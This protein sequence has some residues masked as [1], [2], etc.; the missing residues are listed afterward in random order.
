MRRNNMTSCAWLWF[1]FA[2][3]AGLPAAFGADDFATTYKRWKQLESQGDYAAALK[4]AEAV[5]AISIKQYG[6][7]HA[8]TGR[9]LTELA[10]LY[11]ECG[12]YREA[13]ETGQRALAINEKQYGKESAAAATATLHLG[14]ANTW[15]RR[16]P[17]A[18]SELER[19]L[20]YLEK[21][22]PDHPS[23]PRVAR[24]LCFLASEASYAKEAG[25]LGKRAMELAEKR[26]G[27]D[28]VET[29]ITRVR[30]GYAQYV[31]GE[32]Q[33][34]EKSLQAALAVL[35]SKL[36]KEHPETAFATYR[37]STVYGAS[38]REK[39]R[40]ECLA[41]AE[42]TFAAKLGPQ[43]MLLGFVQND[44]GV[45]AV[46]QGDLAEAERCYMRSLEL[47]K[48]CEAE[49]A[50][51]LINLGIVYGQRSQ[52]DKAKTTF[53]RALEMSKRLLGP[54]HERV[55]Y[56]MLNYGACL[57]QLGN[58]DECLKNMEGALAIFEKHKG[59]VH[60]ETMLVRGNLA[61]I[62]GAVGKE[63]E[64]DDLYKET[65]AEARK[66]LGNQ[67]PDMAHLLRSHGTSLLMR[68]QHAP[69][70]EA[71]RESH[72]IL[73][74]NAGSSHP[75]GPLSLILEAECH[76]RSGDWKQAM[77]T[78][79]RGFRMQGQLA[80]NVLPGISESEQLDFLATHGT[81][82][83]FNALSLAVAQPENQAVVDRT[84]EWTLNAKAMRWTVL[85]ERARRLRLT[86][87]P[88]LDRAKRELLD[89]RERLAALAI[90]GPE[91]GAFKEFADEVVDLTRR[92]DEGAV[93]LASAGAATGEIR[94]WRTLDEVRAA[95]PKDAVLIE[96]A[97]HYGCDFTQPSTATRNPIYGAWIIPPAGGGNVRFTYLGLASEIEQSIA[98]ARQTIAD[99]SAN[100]GTLG[101]KQS[102]EQSREA[103]DALAKHILRPL[104]SAVTKS[105]RWIVSADGAL[106]LVP[107]AALPLENKSYVVE[108]HTICFVA[109]GRDLLQAPSTST[110]AAKRAV[111][112]ADPDYDLGIPGV[113]GP[114][115]FARLP[116]TAREAQEIAPRLKQLS[117]ED[118]KVFTG[119]QATEQLVKQIAQTSTL[120]LSTHGFF[121][122][123]RRDSKVNPLLCCG[124]ALA[125]ANQRHHATD[126][127]DGILTGLEVI[128]MNLSGTRLVVLS[129]CDT[130]VGKVLHGEGVAGLRQA[131]QL[132][133]A[134]S[135]L[136]S[137]W[138]VADEETATLMSSFFQ[139]VAAGQDHS[140]ALREAQLAM[141]KS[142]RAAHDA[143]HP[144]FW[145]SFSLTSSS[146]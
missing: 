112:V 113:G 3:I 18:K 142:R 41:A 131:F 68:G 53:E 63:Q 122:D 80:T 72:A 78:G 19:S 31:I 27:A 66:R 55:G 133:G 52:L 91:N 143:A 46:G 10:G 109:T 2:S 121:V 38:G 36:G 85:S 34:A 81:V 59:L 32:Y 123:V 17:Q 115:G 26:F 9:V 127:N 94:A 54:D 61:L 7:A 57:A 119:E 13:S 84:A 106:W 114:L 28:H 20:R 95:I 120:L 6:A 51:T 42:K 24:E 93:K 107:W 134:D 22:S 14:R 4:E 105:P 103:L 44:Y 128:S 98:A 11:V 35:E 29:A 138:S 90:R 37:L 75:Q 76:A 145:A 116:G 45:M 1:L 96:L 137:L 110:A 64:A 136:A 126:G 88:E 73:E 56:A 33:E 25:E 12:K 47:K 117:G 141:I 39:Q 15:L 65:L 71:F 92:V 67:H 82:S 77:E 89:L 16:F 102:E 69:A 97:L 104:E 79:D 86:G 21:V 146:P 62:Y 111:I 48:A 30:L 8:H 130:G 43:H 135:V 99:S 129:A 58:L 74:K 108:Q 70:G 87:D 50:L 23:I 101:E 118:A 132:A 100:I 49:E 83:G 139:Y 60:R 5:R 140:T 144:A 40:R 124:L 125:G